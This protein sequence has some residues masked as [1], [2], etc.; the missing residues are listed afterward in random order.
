MISK[1][2]EDKK[3]EFFIGV[4]WHPESLNNEDTNNLFCVCIR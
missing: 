3:K 2:L 1:E 4:E